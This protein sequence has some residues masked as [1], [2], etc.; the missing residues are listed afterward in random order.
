M[1]HL[2]LGVPAASIRLSPFVTGVNDIPPLT[3]P[4]V[5]LDIHPEALVDC[6]PGVASYVGAD[7]TA[8]VYSS[9]MDDSPVVTLFLDIGTNGESVLG[10]SEWLV[11]CALL[12]RSG[13]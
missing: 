5:G 12:R 9:G 4:Q 2:L 3:A 1:I 6:L 11:T 8:G 13:L 7:I 10:S